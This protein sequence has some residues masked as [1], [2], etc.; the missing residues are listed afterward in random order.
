M[1]DYV[2][3]EHYRQ[4]F[5]AQKS[6]L[7]I[8]DYPDYFE[9]YLEMMPQAQTYYTYIMSPKRAATKRELV[10]REFNATFAGVKTAEEASRAIIEKIEEE[11]N[12]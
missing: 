1:T 4:L 12:E 10:N 11:L 8:I 7:K 9:G 6:Q 3:S 2:M 5:S